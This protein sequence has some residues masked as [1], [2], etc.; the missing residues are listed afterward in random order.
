VTHRRD[1]W[2]YE[3][4]GNVAAGM[5][6]ARGDNAGD[7]C[8]LHPLLAGSTSRHLGRSI[9]AAVARGEGCG[10]AVRDSKKP[11]CAA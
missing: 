10:G 9:R 5:A 6:C 11:R 8:G 2:W 4:H 3:Q 7:Q 1:G